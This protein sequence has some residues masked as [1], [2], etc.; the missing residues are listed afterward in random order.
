MWKNVSIIF[1]IDTLLCSG[2]GVIAVFLFG[3]LFL[4]LDYP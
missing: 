4:T 1:L 3:C 2:I